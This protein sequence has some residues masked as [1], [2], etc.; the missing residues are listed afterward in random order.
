MVQFLA[1][2]RS[3]GWRLGVALSCIALA[4]MLRAIVVLSF[5]AYSPFAFQLPAVM[6]VTLLCGLRIGLLS[7]VFMLAGNAFLL[8]LVIAPQRF[9]EVLRESS[10]IV[11]LGSLAANGV[12]LVAIAAVFRRTVRELQTTRD[13]LARVA[14]DRETS[15][16]TLEALLAH[17][18]LGTAFFDRAHRFVRVNETVARLNGIS[19]E[20]HQGKTLAEIAPDYSDSV[21]Q[22]V[23]R[24]FST[25]EVISDV[26]LAGETP[27]APG[28]QR[29]WITGFFPVRDAQGAVILAGVAVVEITERKQVERDL[30][31]SVARLRDLAEAVPQ[32]VWTAD[33]GGRGD[34]YNARWG[35]Y[36]G[37]PPCGLA[38]AE[39]EWDAFVHPED[40]AA[41]LDQWRQSLREGKTFAREYRLKAKD[42][43][44]QWFLCRAVPVRNAAGVVERWFGSC[45]DISDIMS[46]R[47]TL[48]RSREDL[49]QLVARRTSE[50][51]EA[52]QRLT[53]E[54]AE[55]EHAE[56]QLRQAQ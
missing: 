26:E 36:T 25:G 22:S 28:V 55:R 18:P 14:K 41:A 24:V 6:I 16:A 32:M 50:L 31:L 19:A 3:L 27:A 48:A 11:I 17:A 37:T 43:T 38:G 30:A 49:E 12:I 54:I 33:G 4:L 8:P 29:H 15:L 35:E 5:G 42:G 44:Y 34:Y 13:S 40:H 47:E 46:A 1:R 7:V 52:N 45:T 23:D 53:A 9:G 20:A 56:D 51:L 39:K 10:S 2:P 21:S